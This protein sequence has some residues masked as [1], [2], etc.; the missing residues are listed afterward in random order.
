[1]ITT[2]ATYEREIRATL[3]RVVKQIEADNQTIDE[4]F[5]SII[6]KRLTSYPLVFSISNS[7]KD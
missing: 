3:D 5:A 6:K 2:V 4:Y 7:I 1:M